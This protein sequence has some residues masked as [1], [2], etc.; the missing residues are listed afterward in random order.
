[1]EIKLKELL[2]TINDRFSGPQSCNMQDMINGKLDF[3]DDEIKNY[4][5]S[6]RDFGGMYGNYSK[7]IDK[8]DASRYLN[9]FTDYLNKRKKSKV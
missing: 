6:L 9:L 8:T 2:N 1:M 3:D 4:L 5:I 7:E